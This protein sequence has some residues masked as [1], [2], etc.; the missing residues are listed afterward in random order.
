M[1]HNIMERDSQTGHEQAWHGLTTVIP[2]ETPIDAAN[3]GICYPMAKQPTF[4]KMPDGSFKEDGQFRIVSLDDSL[5]IG[6]A[7]GKD[8]VIIDNKNRIDGALEVCA[9]YGGTIESVGTVSNREI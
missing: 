3:C 2:R 4:L 8:Y 7:V 6:S 9:K 1:S 5:P